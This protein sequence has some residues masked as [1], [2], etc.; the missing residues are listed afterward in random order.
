MICYRAILGLAD[1]MVFKKEDKERILE[2][3]Q[4]AVSIEV[5]TTLSVRVSE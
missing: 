1:I 4:Q 3:Y 5:Y 2:K